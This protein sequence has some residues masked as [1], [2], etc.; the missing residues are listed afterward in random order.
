MSGNFADPL[1]ITG[2][3]GIFGG[4]VDVSGLWPSL[5]SSERVTQAGHTPTWK[6]RFVPTATKNASFCG[7]GFRLD[8]TDSSMSS[9]QGA[10]AVAQ[11]AGAVGR[12]SGVQRRSSGGG[13]LVDKLGGLADAVAR[14]REL[15]GLSGEND[16]AVIFL[17]DRPR[18]LLQELVDVAGGLTQ[19][20][21]QLL[22]GPLR[23][24]IRL[25][26]AVLWALSFDGRMV[27]FAARRGAPSS[28]PR[29][30]PSRLRSTLR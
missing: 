21:T 12:R 15:A 19:E 1:T 13:R 8:M 5:A 30:G 29:P 18:S 10:Q 22:P 24:L 27:L 16:A 9:N 7:N 11:R 20:S 3:I 14:A 17:P 23:E 25:C 6:A 26:A 4:K 28:N 2:S